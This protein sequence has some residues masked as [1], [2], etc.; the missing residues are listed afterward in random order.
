MRVFCNGEML[1]VYKSFEPCYF[2]QFFI[3]Y[4]FQ[5]FWIIMVFLFMMLHIYI[6]IIEKNNMIQ[7][8]FRKIVQFN[9]SQI[10]FATLLKI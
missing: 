9:K 6:Y 7:N 1:C 8:L 10:I 4:Y 5:W 2:S 3:L